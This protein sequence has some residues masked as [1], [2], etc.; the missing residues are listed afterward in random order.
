MATNH[1][2]FA[3]AL[4]EINTLLK[5]DK[6]VE[7][8]V[9]EEAANYF[10]EKLK[11]RIPRTNRNKKHLADGLKVVVLDDMVQVVFEGD[12]FYWHLVE[13]GHKKVNGGKVKGVHMVQNTFDSDG[14]KIADIMANKIIKKMEG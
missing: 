7:L 2:G 13:H 10:V 12:F 8:D 14:N 1:N 11:P 9:L 3:E 6:R 4:R 5:I